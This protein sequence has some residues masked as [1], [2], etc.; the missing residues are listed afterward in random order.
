M[1]IIG[2]TSHLDPLHFYPVRDIH[3]ILVATKDYLA[4]VESATDKSPRDMLS[5][6]NL[7]LLDKRN[8][9]RQYIEKYLLLNRVFQNRYGRR[10]R[11]PGICGGRT[12]KRHPASLPHVGAHSSPENRRRLKGQCCQEF[13]DRSSFIPAVILKLFYRKKELQP[14]LQFFYTYLILFP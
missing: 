6:A 7:M 9:T 12:I 13:S 4:Q 10:L 8:I 1:G 5:H 2:E 14:E 11:H 3:D